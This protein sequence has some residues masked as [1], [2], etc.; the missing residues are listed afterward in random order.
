MEFLVDINKIVLSSK[1]TVYMT[2]HF[3]EQSKNLLEIDSFITKIAETVLNHKNKLEKIIFN[4]INCYKVTSPKLNIQILFKFGS[5][6]IKTSQ[7]DI[8]FFD[9]IKN[10][11][12]IK[13]NDLRIVNFLKNASDF[14]IDISCFKWLAKI[15]DFRKLYVVTNKSGIQL[16]RLDEYQKEIVETVNKNVI[17]QGV[18]GSGKTN[19]CIEKIILSACKGYKNK[20]LYTTFSRGLLNDTKVKINN[21]IEELEL[22]FLNYENGNVKF[23]DENHKKALENKLGI[24]FFSEDDEKIVEKIKNVVNYLK[25]KVDYFLIQDLYKNITGISSVIAN[26]NYFINEF[27]SKVKN[28]QISNILSKITVSRETLYKEIFGIISGNYDDNNNGELISKNK[29]V[30]LRK[31][32]FS[33]KEC[34]YIYSIGE[35]Y[36]KHLKENNLMDNNT[37]SR[38]LLEMVDSIPKYA[39][40]V[41][42][43]VQDYSQVTLKLLTSIALKS[44]C[45]GDALQMINPTYFSFSTLKDLLFD[46]MGSKV[47]ALKYNYR[48]TKKI[49]EI[50]TNL[51]ELNKQTFGVH[52]FVLKSES[53]DDKNKTTAIYSQGENFIDLVKNSSLDNF[54]FVVSSKEQKDKLKQIVKNQEVLT[55]SEIKG[56]E[57]DTIVTYNLLSDNFDKWAE[58]DRMIVSRKTADENSVYRYYYNIFY[59]GISR[60]KQNLFVVENKNVSRFNDFFSQN[61]EKLNSKQAIIELNNIVS[62]LEFTQDE[63]INRTMEFIKLEQF[64]N[65]RFTA[66]K[67]SDDI[68]STKIATI[69]EVNEKFIQY[70]QYRQAGVEY[71]QK[72]LL[73]EAKN[74]FVLSGDNELISLINAI[75][76]EE[77]A[78][79]DINIVQYLPEL[80]SN[81]VAKDFILSEVKNDVN[82]LKQSLK[83]IKQKLK[84]ARNGK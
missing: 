1:S 41:I 61:F 57:R 34:G 17:V 10:K 27:L 29:Y 42:D 40:C 59:V 44:F 79:L 39:I 78:K 52:N 37:M 46:N 82:S 36:Y 66:S 80:T 26:E 25:T 2:Q 54:T 3:F 15:E 81:K 8:I 55:V 75:S 47:E 4:E 50:L 65:A 5:N 63:I 31:D 68:V 74:Q 7:D 38:Q 76:G 19:V 24:F 13:Q 71:W 35:S 62:K 43:E 18:A 69:I 49:A 14:T 23:L 28:Y 16:P 22:F 84:G 83:D 53:V 77:N 32:S 20:L 60:A 21:Y 51:S 67:I 30:E 64:D 48:N 11:E 70:G 45:V 12:T 6:I 72:G 58:L 33:E 56:L 73:D 9:I